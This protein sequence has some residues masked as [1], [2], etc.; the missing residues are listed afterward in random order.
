MREP[1]SARRFLLIWARRQWRIKTNTF[2][3]LFSRKKKD[4]KTRTG[5]HT[6]RKSGFLLQTGMFILYMFLGLNMSWQ[7]LTK[8]DKRIGSNEEFGTVRSPLEVGF[9]AMWIMEQIE[10]KLSENLPAERKEALF[11]KQEVYSTKF[12]DGGDNIVIYENRHEELLQRLSERFSPERSKEIISFYIENGLAT[13]SDRNR[14]VFK[15]DF[16]GERANEFLKWLGLYFIII[17]PALTLL[18]G[19]GNKNPLMMAPEDE[20]EHLALFPVKIWVLFTLPLLQRTFFNVFALIVSF[21]PLVCSFIALGHGVVESILWS[22]PITFIFCLCLGSLQICYQFLGRF[23]SKK[24]I[25]VCCSYLQLPGYA[26]FCLVVMGAQLDSVIRILKDFALADVGHFMPPAMIVSAI[27]NEIYSALAIPVLLSFLFPITALSFITY[28]SKGGL[29]HVPIESSRNVKV[30]EQATRFPQCAYRLFRDRN[31]FIQTIIFPIMLF[32]FYLFMF[33]DASSGINGVKAMAMLFGAT[34]FI[35]LGSLLNIAAHEGPSLWLLFSASRPITEILK[36]SIH[37]WIKIVIGFFTIGLTIMYIIGIEDMSISRGLAFILGIPSIAY[38]AT[39]LSFAAYPPPTGTE[40]PKPKTSIIYL[41][42]LIA[43]MYG[44]AV[45]VGMPG[46][47]FTSPLLFGLLSFAMWEDCRRRMNYYLDPDFLPP[48]ELTVKNSMLWCMCFFWVQSLVFMICLAVLGADKMMMVMSLS[49]GIAAL[50]V[51]AWAAFWYKKRTCHEMPKA[52]KTFTLLQQGLT[53]VGLGTLFIAFAWIY[54]KGLK[55]YY[56]EMNVGITNE[57][58]IFFFISA[59]IMAPLL[60]EYLFRRLL[61][62][63]LVRSLSVKKALLFG[64]LIFAAVH[65]FASFPPVFCLGLGCA[66]I[67]WRSGNIWSAVGLH[68]FYNAGVVL[69]S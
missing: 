51:A 49:Y 69:F 37:F 50:I 11:K 34:S 42:M 20:L 55:A 52:T 35:I 25:R 58:R 29:P 40:L 39:S 6:K 65:P 7:T 44:Q 43:S 4:E 22:L 2:S 30:S 41:Y 62:V 14:Q 12:V 54:S 45:L 31:Y 8:V 28:Y 67:Y 32:G 15:A 36:K 33:L 18:E 53:I 27:H 9:S 68:A 47:Q 10:E 1:I 5:T 21:P 16:S 17:L 59:V 46:A 66:W 24:W 57:Q 56:P 48:P 63:A 60:E 61:L 19:I 26:L 3:Y 13:F 64:S 23:N 38:I